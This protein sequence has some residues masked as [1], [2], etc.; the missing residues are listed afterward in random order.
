MPGLHIPHTHA[1]AQAF[2]RRLPVD[3]IA[4][5]VRAGPDTAQ[6]VYASDPVSTALDNLQFT[7]G[8]GP[9]V[10]A[11][12]HGRPV[13]VPDLDDP[14]AVGRWP[15][16][17]RDAAAAGAAAVFAF[18]MHIGATSF[19]TVELHRYSPGTLTGP[20]LVTAPLLT[21]DL[22]RTVLGDRP[23]RMPSWASTE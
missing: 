21:D 2:R 23:V 6:L 10:D 5:G 22:T 9:C 19:G 18:P 17:S 13:L 7:L 11:Y 15:G 8:E 12:Q 14:E 1:L 16:F 20:A 3:G 4:I